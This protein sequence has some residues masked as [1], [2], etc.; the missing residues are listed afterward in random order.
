MKAKQLGL[1]LVRLWRFGIAG[2]IIIIK[3][4]EGDDAES[5]HARMNYVEKAKI[6]LASLGPHQSSQLISLVYVISHVYVMLL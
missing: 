6:H 5:W 3:E 2:I 1:K 4:E